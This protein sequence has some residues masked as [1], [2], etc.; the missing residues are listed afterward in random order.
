MRI[1]DVRVTVLDAPIPEEFRVRS[2]VGLKSSRTSVFVEV[3]TDEGL[4]GL[5]SCLGGPPGALRAIVEDVIAP[6]IRGQDPFNIEALWQQVFTGRIMRLSGPHSLGVAALSGVDVALWDIKGKALGVPIYQLLGGAC[7]D[8][9]RVYASSVYWQTPETAAVD[10]R[11]LVDAGFTAV[12]LKVGSDARRDIATVAAVREAIGDDVDLF[13]D[14]N[15]CYTFKLAM[16]VVRELE[17]HRVFWFEEPMPFTDID[18]HKKLT[19]ATSVRIAT[20]ENMYT[21]IGFR[22]V[23]NQRAADI[24]QP[25]ITRCGG[26]TEARKIAAMAGGNGLLFAPHSFGDA[27]CQLA[28]LHVIASCPEAL[29]MEMDI[30]YNPLRTDLGG[31][32]LQVDNGFINLPTAPGLGIELTEDIREAYPYRGGLGLSLGAN[33]IVGLVHEDRYGRSS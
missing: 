20:G 4:I 7:R 16:E 2:G 32:L 13:V 30:T 1:T 25:D 28:T 31:T 27:A 17:R 10:A 14:A 9:V 15:L 29:I 23:V 8:P 33:P 19:D 26:I 11:R 6:T 3:F 5:G 24:V 18:G 12:K 22:E 21:R